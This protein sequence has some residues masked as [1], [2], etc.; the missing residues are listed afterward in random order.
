M[1]VRTLEYFLLEDILQ[2]LGDEFGDEITTLFEAYL[3]DEFYYNEKFFEFIFPESPD[4]IDGMFDNEDA[5]LIW[6]CVQY[7]KASSGKTTSL[8]ISTG[9][10]N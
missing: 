1:Q 8:L 7:I 6:N 10:D 2:E 4:K 5:N 9:L 3:Q